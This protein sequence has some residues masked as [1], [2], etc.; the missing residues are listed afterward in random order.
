MIFLK[1][2][3]IVIMASLWP[4][5]H[6]QRFCT[7]T[8][9]KLN[10][11]QPF[12]VS[13]ASLDFVIFRLQILY[14]ADIHRYAFNYLH[15][16]IAFLVLGSFYSG[17]TTRGWN[18]VCVYVCVGGGGAGA[19]NTLSWRMFEYARLYVCVPK[20]RCSAKHE[21][22]LLSLLYTDKSTMHTHK[23]KISSRILECPC[24]FIL[25]TYLHRTDSIKNI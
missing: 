18:C 25:A 14:I 8:K 6:K 3:A 2:H 21:R 12:Y 23:Y 20:I 19:I 9:A 5:W 17:N 4:H 11:Q 13:G 24:K 15:S 1:C 22:A 10:I 7:T 16:A